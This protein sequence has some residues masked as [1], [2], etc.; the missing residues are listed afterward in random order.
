HIIKG[1]ILDMTPRSIGTKISLIVIGILLVFSGVVAYQVMGQM[2][3]G[4]KMF[5][6]EKAKS[7]LDLAN[8]FLTNKIPG[9]WQIKDGN[10]YKGNT[11]VNDNFDIVD[12]I[13]N[14]T[15]DTVTIFQDNVRVTTN[16]MNEGKRAVGTTV[17]EKVEDVV[18]KNGEKY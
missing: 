17:S 7:D 2:Q 3:K 8:G 12:E 14:I 5:A 16:V 11:K 15:G 10:L 1:D 9:D 6:T 4:I 13:G 18:L